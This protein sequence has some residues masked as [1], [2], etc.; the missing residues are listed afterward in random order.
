M[1]KQLLRDFTTAD[2]EGP[3]GH[4]IRSSI[5]LEALLLNCSKKLSICVSMLVGEFA[6]A[7]FVTTETPKTNTTHY[8]RVLIH[9][10][11]LSFSYIISVQISLICYY[12]F[13]TLHNWIDILLNTLNSFIDPEFTCKLY[14]RRP[15]TARN[16]RLFNIA[17]IF[18]TTN[19]AAA[20]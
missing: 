6:I 11:L 19:T 4:S 2:G 10:T 15:R 5:A 13:R 1:V 18:T 3:S 14:Q 20:L 7:T 9:F 17:V 12:Y 16:I 8:H